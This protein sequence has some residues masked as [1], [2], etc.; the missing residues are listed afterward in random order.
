MSD[1]HDIEALALHDPVLHAAVARVRQG[2][3][4]REE[5]LIAVVIALSE[6]MTMLQG[7]K[8]DA[9]CFGNGFVSVAHASGEF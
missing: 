7:A 2:V 4:S 1:W 8:L 3:V 9:L 5:A 6:R